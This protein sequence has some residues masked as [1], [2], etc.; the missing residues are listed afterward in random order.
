M[1]VSIYSITELITSPRDEEA[2]NLRNFE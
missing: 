1:D 2:M